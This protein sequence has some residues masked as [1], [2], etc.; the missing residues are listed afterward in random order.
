MGVE[1]EVVRVFADAAGEHGNELGIVWDAPAAE[2][3]AQAIAAELGFSETVFASLAGPAERG[4]LLR[5]RIFTPAVELPFAGHPTVG[6]AWWAARRLGPVAAIDVPAGRVEVVAEGGA[7][8]VRARPEW[9]PEF[10]LVELGTPEEVEALDPDAIDAGQRYCWS[11][12]DAAAGEIRARMFAPALGIR[13]DEATGA[14]AVRLTDLLRRDLR[15]RRG[16]GSSL[17][18]R[19]LGSTVAVGGLVVADRSLALD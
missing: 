6:L 5:A 2:D 15:I 17:S 13:E 3:R 14:A 19:R 16:E 18:T 8:F 11:W 10:D 1:V 12:T 4:A 9:T 7:T